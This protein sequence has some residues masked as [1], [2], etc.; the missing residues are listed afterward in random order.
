MSALAGLLSE[1]MPTAIGVGIFWAFKRLNLKKDHVIITYSFSSPSTNEAAEPAGFNDLAKDLLIANGIKP[2]HVSR[3]AFERLGLLNMHQGAGRAEKA[4][5]AKAF[6]RILLYTT[7]EELMKIWFSN[8]AFLRS[9]I[10]ANAYGVVN[11]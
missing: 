2:G 5:R 3:Q 8:A 10:L 9:Y 6:K 4:V 7:D 11:A 1:F